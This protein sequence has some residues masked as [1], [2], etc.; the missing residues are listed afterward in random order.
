[1]SEKT[2]VEDR[3]VSDTTHGELEQISEQYIEE[4]G[5]ET[6][7]VLPQQRTAKHNHNIVNGSITWKCCSSNNI[8]IT[9]WK[10]CKSF[11]MLQLSQK[12]RFITLNL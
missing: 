9:Q 1:M 3:A 12:M 2:A 7:T 4:H 10:T 6:Y 5:G 8:K 11:W